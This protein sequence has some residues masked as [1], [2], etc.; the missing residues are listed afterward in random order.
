MDALLKFNPVTRALNRHVKVQGPPGDFV[1]VSASASLCLIEGVDRT[2][3]FTTVVV[4]K[5]TGAASVAP[6]PTRSTPLAFWSNER[7]LP[8]EALRW[9]M[10]RMLAHS[11]RSS[12]IAAESSDSRETR[13]VVTVTF[14]FF[15]ADVS[16]GLE[17]FVSTSSTRTRFW[18]WFSLSV[19]ARASSASRARATAPRSGSDF[20]SASNRVCVCVLTAILSESCV[21]TGKVPFRD[22]KR[23]L[24]ESHF[25]S[26]PPVSSG[27]SATPSSA[28]REASSASSSTSFRSLAPAPA[29]LGASVFSC[30][31]ALLDLESS[32]WISTPSASAEISSARAT[33]FAPSST[34]R[35]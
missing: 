6:A 1:G 9:G 10:P 35:C 14:L 17:R 19:F 5:P 23:L 30:S 13:L 25:V 12:R 22:E 24:P 2:E 21:F 28:R 33:S 16:R 26:F 11:R 7:S 27:P 20:N 34:I 4:F 31:L 3:A 29:S 32:S 8:A 15:G 18:F